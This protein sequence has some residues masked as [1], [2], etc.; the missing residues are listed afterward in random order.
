MKVYETLLDKKA[1]NVL[2][3]FNANDMVE[4]AHK[5]REWLKA[6]LE[7]Y[8]LSD[9]GD[10]SHLHGTGMLEAI[11]YHKHAPTD[12]FKIEWKS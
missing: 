7:K 12:F 6:T 1:K 10:V 4:E 8:P 5:L 2:S 11:F 3:R 9:V